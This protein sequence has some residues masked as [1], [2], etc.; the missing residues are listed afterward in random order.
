MAENLQFFL[1]QEFWFI[2]AFLNTT[3]VNEDQLSKQFQTIILNKL[4]SLTDE[5]IY[6]KELK[7]DLLEMGK[8][9]TISC[10][11]VS[12][13][14]NFPYRDENTE[15]EYNL[16]GFFQFEV[17]YFKDNPAKKRK[18]YSN[19]DPTNTVYCA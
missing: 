19:V 4:S 17:E 8:N 15:R 13:L 2:S 7:D 18:N 14:D 16:L 1:K 9:I 3:K 11:W 5:D 10:K 6:V 12:Y